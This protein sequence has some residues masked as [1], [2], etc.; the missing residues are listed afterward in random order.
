MTSKCNFDLG[1]RGGSGSGGITSSL[2]PIPCTVSQEGEV[3]D[4]A[5]SDECSEYQI[6]DEKRE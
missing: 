3:L 4:I 1:G 6:K 5:M 2:C